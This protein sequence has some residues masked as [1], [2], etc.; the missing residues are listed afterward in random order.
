MHLPLLR[1]IVGAAVV[2]VA[3]AAIAATLVPAPAPPP[4][5]VVVEEGMSPLPRPPREFSSGRVA[6][7]DDLVAT[8][9]GGVDDVGLTV[10]ARRQ[11]SER[12]AKLELIELIGRQARDLVLD[13]GRVVG[14]ALDDAAFARVMGAMVIDDT[15]YYTDGTV[16]VVGRL[17]RWRIAEVVAPLRLR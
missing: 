10:A 1:R 15:R 3:A 8:G 12:A 2:V 9:S 11:A 7:A 4:A 5:P 13:D 6:Y 17:Q 14:A 16:D